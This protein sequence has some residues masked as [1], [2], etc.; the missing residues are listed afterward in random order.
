MPEGPSSAL[1]AAVP[2]PPPAVPRRLAGGVSLLELSPP[3]AAFAADVVAG[4]S[5]EPRHLLPKWFYDDLG[6]LLFEAICQTPE[7]YIPDVERALLAHHAADIAALI[8]PDAT[9]LE[10][11]AGALTKIRLLLD[12]MDAPRRV[13]PIDI[14][15]DFLLDAARALKAA[16]RHLEVVAVHADFIHL[17]HLPLPD[18]TA[19]SRRVGFMPGSTIGNLEPSEAVAFLRRVHGH[20]GTGGLFVIGVDLEKDPAVLDAAYDDAAGVTAAFNRNLLVRMR[21]ELGAEVDPRAFRHESRWNA[22]RGRVEMHL[23]AESDTVIRL[24]GRSFAFAPGE[25]IHT[26]NSYKYTPERFA[27]VA[28]EAGFERRAGWTDGDGL[29]SL[30]VLEAV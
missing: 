11:G 17:E 16:E 5:A 7:Y 23:V 6:S 3:D 2:E 22:A 30:H 15:R 27:A 21:R 25:G 20:V 10:Y 18:G 28:A 29:F 13:V 19:E 26:E 4:L 24:D 12:A 8:G 14:A 9:V 1:A